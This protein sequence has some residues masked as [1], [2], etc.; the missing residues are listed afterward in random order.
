MKVG[1]YTLG[2][3]LNFAESE[4]LTDLLVKNGFKI[5]FDQPE[6]VIVRG[7]S[8]TKKAEKE[9]RWKIRELKRKVNSFIIAAGCLRKD[10]FLKEADLI[11][12][13]EKEEILFSEIKKI[14][15]KNLKKEKDKIKLKTRSFIKIQDGCQ[16]YCS[17]CLIPYLRG[18]ERSRKSEEIIKMIKEKEKNGYKEIVLTGVNIERWREKDKDLIWLIKKI[19]KKTKIER[20][21][22]SSLW[23]EKID[24]RFL[25]L[26]ENK[27]V[28]QHL[29]LSL[30]SLSPSV[31]KRMGRFYNL[32]KVEK[33]IKK[34]KKKFPNLTLTADII[35]GFPNET[36]KEF[37]QTYKKLKE[38]KLAKIHVFRYSLREGTKAAEM[39]NQ[40]DEKTKKKRAKIIL[41]LSK[42]LEKEWK[43]KNLGQIRQ[44]LFE[45]KK[46]NFWQGLTDNY[47]KVFVKSE[48][49]LANQIL[50]VKLVKL[51]KEGLLGK[52][53]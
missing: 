9:T 18:K 47:L 50:P 19:L 6:I 43:K 15:R 22:I 1:I 27:R 31:L 4:E 5:S 11:I 53:I 44:V 3:R 38:L 52:L 35:V 39:I 14:F 17:Y 10:F 40:I 26:F 13:K 46:D 25:S 48:K 32:E 42:K 8:V 45:K 34:I 33:I 20:I 16:R 23:P 24:D 49:N 37:K 12:P 30:Q 21:R 7:C 51:Y 36:D 28:C 29:H 41:N 2:C